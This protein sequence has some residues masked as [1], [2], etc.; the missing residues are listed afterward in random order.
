MAGPDEIAEALA[1]ARGSGSGDIV[2]LHCVSGYPTPVEQ[3]NL[4]RVRALAERHSVL[5]GLSDHTRGTMCAVAAVAL[6]AVA[7]EKHLTLRR[8][9]GGPD[10]AFSLEPEEF[11]TLVRD[12]RAAF[13]ALGT[14]SEERS[15]SESANAKFRRS[16]YIVR[17]MAAGET[18]TEETVRSI[19]PGLGL[20]PKN[21]R[22]VLGR[23]A[24]CA[25]RRG[26][27][28]SWDLVI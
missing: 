6:G 5:V 26:T 18:F 19:R 24:A 14:G 22:A 15:A 13:A 8:D 9:D 1:V 7:V 23:T 28:L 21:L 25:I 17:D 11:A 2:L 3:S 27:P 20:P 4:K 16:L 10:A 12:C